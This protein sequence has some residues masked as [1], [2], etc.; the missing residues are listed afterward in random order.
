VIDEAHES[1]SKDPTISVLLLM[2]GITVQNN[3]KQSTTSHHI[4]PFSVYTTSLRG[5]GQALEL[6]FQINIQVMK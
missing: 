4:K 2:T 6:K 1:L 3:G 5:F